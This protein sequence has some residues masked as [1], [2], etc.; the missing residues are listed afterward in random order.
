MTVGLKVIGLE[1]GAPSTTSSRAPF[2]ASPSALLMNGFQSGNAPKSV[3]I[4]Q[5]RSRGAAMS[6]DV[7]MRRIGQIVLGSHTGGCA[8]EPP[9]ISTPDTPAS[10]AGLRGQIRA[11]G[12]ELRGLLGRCAAPSAPCPRA[13]YGPSALNF[14][15]SPGRCARSDALPPRQIRAF[16]PELRGLLGRCATPSRLARYGP[17][18]LNFAA[19]SAAARRLRRL[20]TPRRG[21]S[22]LPPALA[23]S[24]GSDARSGERA[25]G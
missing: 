20:A 12:P 8:G 13:R 9:R 5:T 16:G 7:S 1:P 2:R 3:R 14:A 25:R 11:F 21:V 18:A 23:A 15:A 22:A 24:S 17:S 19:F 10:Q 6:M 4:D